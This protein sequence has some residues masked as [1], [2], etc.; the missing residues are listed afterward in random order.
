MLPKSL[1]LLLLPILRAAADS[2]ASPSTG[3]DH[4]LI[5]HSG[6]EC[7]PKLF[8]PSTE[9][10]PVHNDQDLPPGLHVRLNLETGVKEAKLSDPQEDSESNAVVVVGSENSED[11]TIAESTDVPSHGSASSSE[12]TEDTSSI[13]PPRDGAPGDTASFADHTAVVSQG[14][15]ASR[16]EILS[17]L[18]GLEDLAHE[19]YWGTQLAGSS[20]RHLLDLATTSPHA[21]VRSSAAMVL[22]SACSNNPKAIAKGHD[23]LGG[24]R[25]V[26]RL[27]DALEAE[28]DVKAGQRL[29]FALSQMVKD[30]KI[31]KVME[32]DTCLPRLVALLKSSGDSAT[33]GK[34]AVLIEDAF[35]NVDLEK[36]AQKAKVK[37]EGQLCTILQGE[38][39]RPGVVDDVKEKMFSALVSLKRSGADC[40]AEIALLEWMNMMGRMAEGRTVEQVEDDGDGLVA[41]VMTHRKDF[42]RELEDL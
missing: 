39:V 31:Q 34:L 26:G 24:R 32:K 12:S 19:I 14:L 11:D 40:E 1:L 7:Y 3:N 20:F 2:S 5:C 4:E 15:K 27:M 37:V 30:E 38:L 28:R 8:V 41:S 6:Q 23:T 42:M 17:A 25:I 36:G 35:L 13:K 22:G 16:S 18:S 33:K 21:D 9:F 29:V 10:K